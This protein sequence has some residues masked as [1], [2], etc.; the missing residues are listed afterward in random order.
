MTPPQP[1]PAVA[2][3]CGDPAGIGPEVAC[4]TWATT[5][6]HGRARL[7]VVAEPALLREVLERRRGM[8]QLNIESVAVDDPRPS[9]P[10]TVLVIDPGGVAGSEAVVPGTVSAAGGASAARAVEVAFAA[11][12]AGHAAAIV[13]GPPQGGPPCRRLRRARPHRTARPGL[14]PA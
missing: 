10:G 6:A 12:R 11:T 4:L 2:L 7:R 8:P 1:F 9:I 13:T 14:R 5:A 3:T